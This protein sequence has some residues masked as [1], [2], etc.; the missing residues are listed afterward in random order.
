MS[1]GGLLPRQQHGCP[2]TRGPAG[3]VVWSLI[4][5]RLLRLAAVH[6]QQRAFRDVDYRTYP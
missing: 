4:G 1:M 2:A 3:M 6:G 5:T